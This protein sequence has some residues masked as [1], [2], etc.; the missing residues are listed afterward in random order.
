MLCFLLGIVRAALLTALPFVSKVLIDSFQEGSQL[1]LQET[2]LYM[3][4]LILFPL[5]ATLCDAHLQFIGRR[6]STHLYEAFTL[7]IY[8]KSLRLTTAAR[9]QSSTGQ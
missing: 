8:N 5:F 7:A 4:M 9:T 3:F 6:A 2:L 1:E